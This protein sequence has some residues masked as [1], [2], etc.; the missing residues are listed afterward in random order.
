VGNR[1]VYQKITDRMIAVLEQGTVPW[2]KPWTAA[3]GRPVS[4]S[5]GEPYRGVNVFLLAVEA[6]DK[7]HRS[8]WWGTYNQIAQLTGMQR[9][10]GRRGGQYWASPDGGPRGVRKG[11]HGCQVVL[12]KKVPHTETDPSTDEKTTRQILL[13]R[14]FTVFNAEQADGLPES[15]TAQTGQPVEQLRQPQQVLEGYLRHG[16][17]DLRHVPGDR[18]CYSLVTDTITL[19]EQ[20]QFRTAEGYYATAFHE[21]AHSTGHSSRLARASLTTFSHD[22]TWGDELY[23]KE[24]LAAEMTSAM[25]QADT[26][27]DSE[28][29][30]SAAYIAN[31]LTALRSDP[32][33]IPQSAACAQ[34]ASDLITQPQATRQPQDEAEAAA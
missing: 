18:A 1:E 9:H 33:L 11:E 23:A 20:G 17:P 19:P 34:R 32:T 29:E 13:A 16:G 12:W 22:R 6:M 24:E 8:R 2:R 15:Y 5:T 14:L 26:R 10:A 21:A 25:L 30:Q 31:W 27:I 7:G 28:F 4:M 3:G